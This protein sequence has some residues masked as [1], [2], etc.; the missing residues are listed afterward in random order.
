MSINNK[1]NLFGFKENEKENIFNIILNNDIESLSLNDME[2]ISSFI[3]LWYT[4]SV[5]YIDNVR[6]KIIESWWLEIK[7]NDIMFLL[8]LSIITYYLDNNFNSKLLSFFDELQISSLEN[9]NSKIKD[10]LERYK[11]DSKYFFI[12]NNCQGFLSFYNYTKKKDFLNEGKLEELEQDND[13]LFENN[14]KE[15]DF[16]IDS[17][18]YD[19]WF[20]YFNTLVSYTNYNL[21]Y[22][23]NSELLEKYITVLNKL[24]EI[25]PDLSKFKLSAKIVYI[26]N[27]IILYRL[28]WNE[29][30]LDYTNL[31]IEKY[32]NK[33]EKLNWLLEFSKNYSWYDFINKKLLS[34]LSFWNL[35]EYNIDIDKFALSQVISKNAI[36]WN[37]R[38][39]IWNYHEYIKQKIWEKQIFEDFWDI[40]YKITLLQDINYQNTKENLKNIVWFNFKE[41]DDIL[42]SIFIEYLLLDINKVNLDYNII[43][44]FKLNKRFKN[45]NFNWTRKEKENISFDINYKW[46]NINIKLYFPLEMNNYN[47]SI[48]ENNKIKIENFLSILLDKIYSLNNFFNSLD[49]K[50]QK[51]KEHSETIKHMQKISSLTKLVLMNSNSEYKQKLS[52]LADTVSLPLNEFIDLLWYLHDI[53]KSDNVN[54]VKNYRDVNTKLDPYNI[55]FL[56]VSKIFIGQ[57]LI[58]DLPNLIID[59]NNKNTNIDIDLLYKIIEDDKSFKNISDELLHYINSY[60]ISG[61]LTNDFITLLNKKVF[62]LMPILLDKF[63]ELWINPYILNYI[64]HDNFSWLSKGNLNL[65]LITIILLFKNISV[66]QV[67]ELTVPH[68]IYWLSFFKDNQDFDYLNSVLFHHNDYPTKKDIKNYNWDSWLKKINDILWLDNNYL[69][70]LN[71]NDVI[72]QKNKNFLSVLITIADLIDALLSK[73]S[74]QYTDNNTFDDIILN[75]FNSYFNSNI[76]KVFSWEDLSSLEQNFDRVFI[77]LDKEFEGNKDYQKLK[78]NFLIKKDEI[79][80]SYKSNNKDINF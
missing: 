67:K 1:E 3:S 60:N 76:K 50:I 27:I 66:S 21:L 41:I 77:I 79:I 68:I 64:I 61:L 56:I 69:D 28:T 38:N 2:E 45:N 7:D 39:N 74:Y 34:N 14:I 53:W 12:A 5:E 37:I 35:L 30:Y 15:L 18:R 55:F 59:E 49:K 52:F 4:K 78:W 23:E 36:I 58:M 54:Y 48:I 8:I 80:S 6:N 65:Y 24:I 22:L 20:N 9:I 63:N 25:N 17:K 51:L 62:K 70:W 71:N 13:K 16:I 44:P 40:A 11:Q 31:I 19:Y 10:L 72:R 73:R 29:R 26:N 32:I 42:K 47:F 46:E 43:L 33:N 75:Y 57:D